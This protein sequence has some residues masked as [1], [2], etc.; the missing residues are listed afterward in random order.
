VDIGR[1]SGY[2]AMIER[3]YNYFVSKKAKEYNFKKHD[4]RV[5]KVIN[6]NDGI[7]QNEICTIIKEDKIT[8]SKAVKNLVSEGYV[9]RVKDLEDG[10]VTRLFM[11]EEGL[12]Y[13]QKI[14]MIFE[15]VNEIF[16][17]NFSDEERAMITM[18]LKKMSDNIH[19]EASKLK[20]E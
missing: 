10:R 11:T 6:A 12:F 17:R 20:E 4:I 13:R 2:I 14:L 7:S 19:V 18:L 3:D 9:K 8:V 5:L 15:E 16:L 1:I